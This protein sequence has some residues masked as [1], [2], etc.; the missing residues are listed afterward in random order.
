VRSLSLFDVAEKKVELKK[1]KRVL[2]LCTTNSCR[3]QMAEG[4][5]KAIG[6][7]GLEVWSAGTESTSVHPL[8]AKVMAESGIDISNQ[9]SKSVAK[10]QGQEFDYMIT[11]C[12]ENA[13]DR[14][15]AFIGQTKHRLHWDFSDPADA[16]GSEQEKLDVFRKIRDQIRTRIEA[17][18]KAERELEDE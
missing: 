2:F 8:A 18:V 11:L 1:K 13:K 17:F 12:G 4:I 3:S 7:N 10:F 5:L 6:K 9:E 14:C 15:P 16:T